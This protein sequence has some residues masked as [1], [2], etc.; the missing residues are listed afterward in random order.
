VRFVAVIV[1]QDDNV[2]HCTVEGEDRR[3]AWLALALN[4]HSMARHFA[5]DQWLQRAR[6]IVLTRAPD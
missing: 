1:D 3:H 4:Q 6:S 2:L 5:D